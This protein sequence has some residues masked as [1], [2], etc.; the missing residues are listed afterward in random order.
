MNFKRKVLKN[1]LRILVVPMKDAP[2]VTVMAL[3]EA[4][5]EYETKEKNGISHFLEHMCFKGTQK[6]P[7]ALH[8]TKEL[9]SIGSSYNAFTSF[10]LTGYYAKAHYKHFNKI[11]D[12]ISDI[13]Q[14][15]VFPEAEMEREKGVILEEINMYEDTPSDR[16]SEIFDELLYGDTPPGW[17]IIGP[18]ENILKMKKQD[19]LDYHKKHYVPSKTVFVVSGNVDEKEAFK[20]VEAIFGKL[21]QIK[22]IR[23]KKPV[24]RQISPAIKIKNKETDQSHLV[25]G[26]RA[27]RA[28]DKRM[29]VLKVLSVI[30]GSG[31]SSRLWHKMREELGICYY[32]YTSVNDFTDHGHFT[33]S[34]G[35][36]KTRIAIAVEEILNQLKKI[37]EEK[38]SVEELQKAKDYMIGRMYLGLESSNSLANFYGGQEIMREKIK[39]PK[40]VEKEIRRVSVGD[41]QRLAK[42]IFKGSSLN[43]AVIGNLE[44]IPKLEN[45]LKI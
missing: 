38:V 31:M 7:T 1:G 9:D 28:G 34:A 8:I 17:R 2:S 45:I 29:P 21:P 24:E 6:R 19:F 33:V 23:K 15:S 44:K 22:P 30:L 35:V 16:V 25:L 36:D 26:F 12:I 43:L 4:G 32:V 39:T 41:L 5:S 40:E 42:S 10:E 37:K 13:Y 14:N 11:L 3:V 18:K 27:F 20:K